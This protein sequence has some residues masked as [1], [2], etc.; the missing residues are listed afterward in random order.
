VVDFSGMTIQVK[1][2]QQLPQQVRIVPHATHYT[3]EVIYEQAVKSA[4]V[5]PNLIAGTDLGVDNVAAVTSNQP[6]LVPFLLNGRPLKSLNQWKNKRLIG[7]VVIGRMTAGNSKSSW[8]NALIRP[9]C[10]CHMLVLSRC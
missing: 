1:T 6:G 7:T 4:D 9:L 10:S 8:A 5:D 2:H 3:V